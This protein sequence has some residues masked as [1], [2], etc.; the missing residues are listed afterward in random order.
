L[1]HLDGLLA[2]GVE[3]FTQ[4][5]DGLHAKGLHDLK[6]LAHDHL[7]ARKERI[8]VLPVLGARERSVHG[9]EYR[10][11]RAEDIF[12][13]TDTRVIHPLIVSLAKANGLGVHF[14]DL[15]SVFL[16]LT[17]NLVE[18]LSHDLQFFQ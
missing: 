8:E 5:F 2:R 17:L 9:I 18:L 1:D 6:E 12:H 7:D 13:C 4:G 15:L 11:D 14:A 3:S 16:I 10:D